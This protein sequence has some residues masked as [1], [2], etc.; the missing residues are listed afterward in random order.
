MPLR[1]DLKASTLAVHAG[2]RIDPATGASR[3]PIYRTSAFAFASVEEMTEAFS[4]RT[5]RFIYTRYG[6]PSLSE[7]EA[8]VAALEGAEGAAVFASGMAAITAAV[9][10]AAGAGD[11]LVA[12]KTLYGG[13]TRLFESLLARLGIEV[14][15]ASLEE[16]DGIG[17]LLRPNTKAIY[18]ETPTN[19]TIDVVDIAAVGATAKAAG[20]ELIV[21]N[22][23]ASPVNQ[24]PLRLGAGLVLHSATKFLAGHGDLIAGVVAGRGERLER[25]R[26]FR[27]E[28]GGVLDP[29]AAWILSRSLRTLPLR[30]R[31]QNAN[32]SALA[33]ALER[34]PRVGR[35]HYPGLASHPG[36]G[37]ARRQM[38][39]FGGM[40][41]FELKGG[42]EAARRF[43]EALEFVPLLPT[44]G[45]VETS[46]LIPSLS[47]H[48]MI[49]AEAR[50]QAGVTDGLVRLS[51]GVEDEAD[52]IA[53]V[54]RALGALD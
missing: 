4:G 2:A 25:I 49:S 22:T 23:F 6:N 38:S 27:K 41:S 52:L 11:H 34:S 1:P 5:E 37:V 10:S 32:A 47:S 18:L 50:R 46:V 19:P 3:V 51:A 8:C 43:V 36:H 17:R 7:A 24:Q 28:T 42:A 21:D 53:E 30:I 16:I 45:G 54:E 15:F 40:L 12:Q 13:T 33:R 14:S 26:S 48:S 9:L 35:V 44:L 29:E 20:V 39:G 31:A